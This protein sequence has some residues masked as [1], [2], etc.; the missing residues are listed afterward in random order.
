MDNENISIKR[1]IQNTFFMIKYAARYDKPLIVKIIFL[2]VFSKGIKAVNDTF[3]LKM[4][5]NGITGK[6]E[7]KDLLGLLLISFAL[8]ICFEWINQLI[9]EW[10][11]A[12][13]IKLSGTIQR[14]LIENNSKMDLIYYDNPDYYDT[15]VIVANNADSAIEQTVMI[16]SKTLGGIVALGIA[17]CLIFTVNPFL[18][19]FPVCGFTVNLLTRFKIEKIHYQWDVANRKALRKADY[20]KRVF[21]QPEFAKECKLT[22]VKEPLRLQFDEAF[23]E[24]ADAG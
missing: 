21:Y 13:L 18:A 23:I 14:D 10:S 1:I 3:I 12:K 16:V 15:Y 24:A 2:Y 11:K 9:E 6:A 22:D 17:S 4:L 8:V 19:V 5:I 7:F 20:S